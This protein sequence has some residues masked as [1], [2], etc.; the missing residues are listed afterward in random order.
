MHRRKIKIGIIGCG[1]QA[2]K[3]VNGLLAA[4]GVELVLSDLKPSRAENLARKTG[5]AWVEN[6]REVFEDP[7]IDAVDICTPTPSHYELI[8]QAIEA[9]KD[10]FVEKPLCQSSQQARQLKRLTRANGRLGM[11]GYLYRFVPVFDQAKEFFQNTPRTGH[12]DVLGQVVAACFRIGGR[13]SHRVWKHR[14][15]TGGGAINEM[16]VHMLDLAIWY[17]G[18]VQSVQVPVNK[19]LRPNRFIRG[20]MRTVDAEDYVV[21]L[22]TMQNGVEVLI[23]ADLVTPGF[24]QLVEIQGDNGTFM[25]SIQSE[26]PSFLYCREAVG[27]FNPGRNYLHY[28][29]VNLFEAQMAEFAA[30]LRERRR[31]AKSTLDDSVLVLEAMEKIKT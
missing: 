10:Y 21:A 16:M 22:L 4:P 27:D 11:V 25:G 26:M 3:H 1:K 23:Q 20:K 12:S 18:P 6:P 30:V 13:G 2:P 14:K 7:A 8:V 9:G 15:A 24:T 17:F 19:L 31:P 28:G 29:S 5:L